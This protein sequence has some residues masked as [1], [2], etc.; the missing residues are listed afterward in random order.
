MSNDTRI[1]WA[2]SS[3]DITTRTIPLDGGT[4]IVE[5]TMDHVEVTIRL[6]S[7]TVFGI[8]LSHL[9]ASALGMAIARPDGVAVPDLFNMADALGVEASDLLRMREGKATACACPDDRCAGY[10]HDA[11]LDHCPCADS[12]AQ[13]PTVQ[14]V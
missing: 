3:D 5:H 14:A 9:E 12:L 7:R 13:D 8:Q 2:D 1:P 6:G 4:A 10:H 11:D